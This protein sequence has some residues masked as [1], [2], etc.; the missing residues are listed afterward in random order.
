MPVSSDSSRLCRPGLER[1]RQMR[2]P[3]FVLE[4]GSEGAEGTNAARIGSAAAWEVMS[5]Q[6]FD[7][8]C[9]AKEMVV[10]TTTSAPDGQYHLLLKVTVST[11][12]ICDECLIG[13]WQLD[14]A[15]YE[16]YWNATPAGE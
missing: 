15:S 7:V 2:Y 3:H 12:P 10:L 6:E 8:S 4:V 1:A 9:G 16:A 5:P 14:N 11:G 13:L